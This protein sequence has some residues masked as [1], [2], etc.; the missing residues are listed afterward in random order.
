MATN[1]SGKDPRGKPANDSIDELLD[2]LPAD[3]ILPK[4]RARPMDQAGPPASHDRRAADKVIVRE[5]TDPRERARLDEEASRRQ[6]STFGT[7]F[8]GPNATG[9]KLIVGVVM[10]LAVLGIYALVR[11]LTKKPAAQSVQTTTNSESP[12]ATQPPAPPLST[13]AAPPVSAA[14]NAPPAA[15]ALTPRH[16]HLRTDTHA[17]PSS[18][19][20]QPASSSRSANF[21]GL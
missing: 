6:S 7:S 11:T 15:S 18:N 5:G 20:A 4:K 13:E 19:V 12:I 8:L 16:S 3:P 17:V 10:M 1:E 21:S 9:Q 2:G 14:T